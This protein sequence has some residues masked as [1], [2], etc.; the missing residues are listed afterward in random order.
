MIYC[1]VDIAKHSHEA[2]IVNEQGDTVLEL[3]VNNTNAGFNK[4]KSHLERFK[5]SPETVEFCMEATGHYW[6]SLYCYLQELG[7][8]VGVV[9]PIQSDALRNMYIRKSKTDRKDA[10]ILADLLR[11]GR[12]PKTALASE[13]IMKLQTLSRT[14]F[15]FVRQVGGLK[16]RVL[17]VLDRIFPE[18]PGCFSNVFVRSSRELLKKYTAPEDLA[19]ADISELADFLRKH[20]RNQLGKDRAEQI[21]ALAKGTI[22]IHLAKEAFTL[23]LR[24]LV[25][26]IEFIEEQIQVIE[27]ATDQV[28][29]EFRPT[30][31]T[32]YRHVIETV[33]GIGPVL[34]AAIIGELGDLNNFK[35]ARSVVAYAGLDPTVRSSGQFEGTRNRMSKRGSPVLRHS[36]W[37]AAFTARRYVPEFKEYYEKKL[38]EGK[39]SNVANGAVARRLT[40]MIYSLCKDQRPYESNYKWKAPG[41][42]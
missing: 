12:V 2:C 41:E 33:P 40:H 35:N 1:G 17:G 13:T 22:G 20:S 4:L 3:K 34:A 7:Y 28:M 25:E 19:N 27:E 21:Q 29:E 18:Y 31:D 9:N 8:R 24:L 36:L 15:E 39:H 14:R 10:L 42:A 16:N 11:L 30:A 32:P 23:E 38:R 26:Q 37:L 5:A 6:L